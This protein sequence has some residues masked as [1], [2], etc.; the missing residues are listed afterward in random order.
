LNTTPRSLAEALAEEH[1]RAVVPGSAPRG[2][3]QAVNLMA[4]PSQLSKGCAT[5]P[6]TNG[7]AAELRLRTFRD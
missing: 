6:A 1:E 5:L 2:N 4:T 3:R 7:G